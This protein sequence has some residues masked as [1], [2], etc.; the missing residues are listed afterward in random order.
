MTLNDALDGT[1]PR[2]QHKQITPLTE[3]ITAHGLL[4]VWRHQ[5]PHQRQYFFHSGV[6]NSLS[7]IDYILLAID[8]VAKI[9]N[10]T[11]LPRG[12]SDH[13]PILSEIRTNQPKQTRMYPIYPGFLQNPKIRKGLSQA[14]IHYFTENDHSVDSPLTLWEAYKPVLLGHAISLIEGHKREQRREIE[15][16]EQDIQRLELQQAKRPDDTAAQTLR[17]HREKY[18]HTLWTEAQMRYQS[19]QHKIYESGDKAGKLLAW[20]DKKNRA[21][22]WITQLITGKGSRVSHPQEIVEELADYFETIYSPTH[23]HTVQDE[24][25]FIRD[26]KLT[27]LSPQAADEL[28]AD[29]TVDEITTAI[30]SLQSGKAAG[31]NGIPIELYKQ[32]TEKTVPY[33]LHMFENSRLQGELPKDQRLATIIAIHKSGKPADLSTSYRPISLINTE[34]KI[35]AK[36]LALRLTPHLPALIQPDQTGFMPGG[37]TA[38]NLRRLHNVLGRQHT[39]GEQAAILSL[40]A[41]M[42]FDSVEWNYL[43]AVLLHMGFGPKFISWVQLLYTNPIAHIVANG[44]IS[45]EIQLGQGTRQGCPLSPLLF[46]LALEPL[47]TWIRWT[48]LIRGLKWREDIEDRISLYA[49]DILI[50]IASPDWSIHALLNICTIFGSMSGYA[51][52]WDKSVLYVLHGPTPRL[53]PTCPIRVTTDTFKYLGIHITSDPDRFYTL[54]LKPPLQRLHQD[55]QHWKTLPLTLLGRAALF[56][57]MALPR[58]LYALHNTPYPVSDAYFRAINAE[59]SALLWHDRPARVA[60]NKLYRSWYDGGIALPDIKAYYWA[61]QLTSVNQ[62]FHKPDTDPTYHLDR[63]ILGQ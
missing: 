21:T 22:R 5:H 37:N 14:T 56:K 54:N 9:G 16:L 12:I 41:K 10:T 62:L 48:P 1:P 47:A 51:I 29:L 24:L 4:D 35:L 42:A 58:F 53:P 59:V 31:P 46:A 36:T 60:A 49:D 23:T 61:A 33:M 6:H 52:N 17:I 63:L 11:I 25:Q 2:P 34:P 3:F 55:V 7:R 38:M 26:I 13:S 28:D 20:L 57:M 40:D 50:Y 15:Q 43:L 44:H 45:R 30:H 32:N 8:D 27:R 19:T 39:I 18:K